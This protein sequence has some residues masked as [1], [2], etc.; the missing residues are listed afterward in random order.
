MLLPQVV[1]LKPAPHSRTPILSYSMKVT[2][3]NHF[4]NWQQDPFSNYLGRLVFPEKTRSFEV[5][6]DLVA[7]MIIINPFDF[8]LEPESETFP[9]KYS[10]ELKKELTPYLAK[11]PAGPH[12]KAFMKKIDKKKRQ[13]TQFLVDLN[14]KLNSEISYL[15][16]MEPNVQTCEETLK[17]KSGSCRDSAWLLV[18]ILRHL[19][20]AARFVSGYLI[21]LA[22]DVKS[23]DGPSG[24]EA[25]FTDLH[26][27]TEVF[28]PGAGWVGRG[29]GAHRALRHRALGRHPDRGLYARDGLC[30]RRGLERGVR[31]R[32]HALYRRRAVWPRRRGGDQHAAPARA[33]PDGPARADHLQVGGVW[34]GTRSGVE[35][36]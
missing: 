31:Q 20:L 4:I 1:R 2:P 33:R 12:F 30:Q 28:L 35:S 23:L 27:W 9:F 26:A 24:P 21:Q 22:Q 10:R 3:E 18:N 29:P 14:L 25:D 5:E 16:R 36:S 13:T 17:L 11:E 7:D 34:T 8:F 19:G 32:Q 15:I 6:I